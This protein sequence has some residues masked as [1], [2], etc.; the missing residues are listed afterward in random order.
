MRLVFAAL[1]ALAPA[2]RAAPTQVKAASKI[3]A[4]TVYLSAAR[5]ARTA[6]ADLPAGEV[7]LVLEG[8]TERLDDDS[9][10]VSGKGSAKA[11]VAGVQTERMA[12]AEAL[13]ADVRAAQE[14]V[15]RLEEQ[16]R[17]FED[18]LKQAD[19]RKQFL[20]GLRSTYIRERTENLA[21][22]AVDTKEWTA[23]VEFI[24]KQYDAM[25]GDQRKT[26]FAR[27]EHHKLLQQARDELA[28]LQA[29]G[30]R[31][32]KTVTVDIR[33][34][35]AGSF[36]VELSYLVPNASWVPL[37]D[38]RLDPEAESLELQLYAQ[39]RQRSGE[40]WNEVK[41]AVS[42]AQP[43]RAIYVP[44]L[45][46][47][48]LTKFVPRP[49][50]M[51]AARPSR[52]AKMPMAAAPPAAAREEFEALRAPEPEYEME[53]QQAQVEQ[54]LL[55]ATYTSPSRETVDGQGTPRKA[56]LGPFKLKAELSR[57]VAPRQDDTVFLTAKATNDTGV[58]LLPGAANLFVGDEFVG[59]TSLT[60]EGNDLKL[61]FG[62]DDRVK[63]ERRVI[64]R[65]REAP[66]LFIKEELWRYGAR[67]TVKNHY[68]KPVK[69]TVLDLAPVSRDEDIKV[70]VLDKST[71]PT[72]PEDAMKPGVRGYRYEIAPK[73]EQAIE[74][75]YEVRFPPGT[76]VQGLE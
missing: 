71:R 46:P 43:G 30:S 36:E 66:G 64:E 73:G 21:V 74:L 13:A 62:P 11:Q 39:V 8:L 7:R 45:Q 15:T 58:M 52:A 23:L 55:A 3:D 9:V 76:Q 14:K 69:V 28:K 53:E 16:D 2:A 44:E 72:E 68:A 17:V 75:W 61:A 42:T 25:W 56:F 57:T 47:H 48:Y 37:W 67:T 33:V 32:S 20:D 63:A 41:L 19:A 5:V 10:R 4:V 1:L 50:P 24:G 70:T 38:A 40:D 65:R 6:R 60:P 34:E 49:P 12:H 51:P 26:E 54:G 59:K 31:F 18:Q 22:R 35:K 29:K 27:R